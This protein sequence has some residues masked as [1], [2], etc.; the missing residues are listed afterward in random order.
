MRKEL[1]DELRDLAKRFEALVP[2]ASESPQEIIED[3][4]YTEEQE[5][6]WVDSECD[7]GNNFAKRIATPFPTKQRRRALPRKK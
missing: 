6:G 7:I 1:T 4:I 5:R 2:S 3:Y